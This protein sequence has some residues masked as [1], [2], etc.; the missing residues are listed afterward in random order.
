MPSALIEVRRRY[1][2]DEEAAI[3]DAVHAALVDAFRIPPQ[4]KHLR[5]VVHEPH[6]F[7][8][9]PRLTHPE[10]AT[11][12]SID[13]FAGRSLDA[14]RKLYTGIVDR[15]EALGVPRDHVMIYLR[16][17]EPENWG[18]GGGRAACDIELGFDVHV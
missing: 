8:C 15:L 10:R 3:I 4:D 14:K 9:S 7:A 2:D 11:I 16:E 17:I 5:L 12:V 13:C 1:S 18:I 6:R